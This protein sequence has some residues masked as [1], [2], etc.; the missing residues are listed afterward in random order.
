MILITIFLCGWIVHMGIVN[1]QLISGYETMTDV[2]KVII[3][4]YDNPLT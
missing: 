4:L 1:K 2:E 3:T